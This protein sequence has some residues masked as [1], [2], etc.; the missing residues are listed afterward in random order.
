M[1]PKVGVAVLIIKENKILV[2]KRKSTSHGD[3]TWHTPGGHLEFGESL[4]EC[5]KREVFEE[6]GIEIENP[7]FL[8][9]TNDIF[10]KEGKHYI[11]IWMVSYWKKGEPITKEPEKCEGWKWL[12]LDEIKNLEPLFLPLENL[13][14]KGEVLKELKLGS[15]I[16]DG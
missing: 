10:Q 2:G 1:R 9:V 8:T 6:T 16:V 11:T 15:V 4:E 12:S 5:A 3:G 14:K 13:L 7:K